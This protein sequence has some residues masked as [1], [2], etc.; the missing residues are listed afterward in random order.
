MVGVG[1]NTVPEKVV[2]KENPFSQ[3]HPL[4]KP[5]MMNAGARAP[6]RGIRCRGPHPQPLPAGY[7]NAVSTP[8]HSDWGVC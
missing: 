4:F 2:K 5:Q 3:R 1:E 7:S 6:A 8:L